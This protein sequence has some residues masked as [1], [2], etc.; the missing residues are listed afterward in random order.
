MS[1]AQVEKLHEFWHSIT[2]HGTVSNGDAF[3]GFRSPIAPPTG[4]VS[5]GP[6]SGRKPRYFNVSISRSISMA[7]G[8][9]DDT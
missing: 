3:E 2:R 9:S 5:Q 8:T 4:I 7:R 6:A 1:K